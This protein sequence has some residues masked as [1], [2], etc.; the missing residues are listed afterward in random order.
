MTQ[1]KSTRRVGRPSYNRNDLLALLH[2]CPRRGRGLVPL[3][4]LET[5]AFVR[6]FSALGHQGILVQL[7]ADRRED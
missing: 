7:L 4:D 1:A 5:G 6:R 3:D 2:R